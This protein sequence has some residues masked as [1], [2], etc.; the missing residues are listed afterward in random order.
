MTEHKKSIQKAEQTNKFFDEI[1]TLVED[2][3]GKELVETFQRIKTQR[4][5]YLREQWSDSTNEIGPVIIRDI[6]YDHLITV[7]DD[8]LSEDIDSFYQL[9]VALTRVCLKYGEFEKG[10]LLLS[11]LETKVETKARI[12]QIKM[13]FGKLNLLMNKWDLSTEFYLAGLEIYKSI[14]DKEGSIKAYNN[15]GIN[16]YEQWQTESGKKYLEKAEILT[17]KLNEQN[18]YIA[19]QINLGIVQG[20]RGEF[21]EAK[22][23]FD[24]L[25]NKIDPGN[26]PGRA[27]LLINKGMAI[28]G[29]ENFEE[30][31]NVLNESLEISRQIQNNRMLALTFLALAEVDV[32]RGDYKAANNA[33]NQAF[34]IFAQRHDKLHLASVYYIF[35]LLHM[36]EKH[37]ELSDSEFR[38]SLRINEDYNEILMLASV[39]RDYSKLAQIYGETS[40][41][42]KRLQKA[43]DLFKSIQAVK[44]AERIEQELK[45]L[46]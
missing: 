44:R 5:R 31:A 36:F 22:N 9:Y 7:L 1:L 13:L 27:T 8:F 12:A 16:S 6:D 32:Y 17:A 39:Y 2:F 45:S 43:L 10:R 35:G 41:Q 26:R 18:L 21:E 14:G 11:K 29:L 15:L 20:M 40:V 24:T 23:T 38:M 25:L 19:V 28:R 30:A 46:D 4:D 3:N 34:T 37:Y 42:K 33:L